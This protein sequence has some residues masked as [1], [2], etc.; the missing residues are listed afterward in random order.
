[1]TGPRMDRRLPRTQQLFLARARVLGTVSPD[2]LARG[3]HAMV[4]RLLAKG[5]LVEEHV[6]GSDLRWRLPDAQP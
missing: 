1:M 4:Q 2:Q 5:L 6:N 3:Q